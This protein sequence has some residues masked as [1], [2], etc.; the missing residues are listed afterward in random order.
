MFYDKLQA[1]L[2][3]AGFDGFVEPGCAAARASADATAGFYFRMLLARCTGALPS[4][5]PSAPAVRLVLTVRSAD[6]GPPVLV[7][8]RITMGRLFPQALIGIAD[9]VV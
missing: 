6:A 4:A 5:R 7:D 9:E 1:V 8:G 2:L 3:A